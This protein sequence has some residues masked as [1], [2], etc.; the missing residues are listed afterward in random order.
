MVLDEIYSILFPK[1]IFI[2]FGMFKGHMSHIDV[3]KRCSRKEMRALGRNNP[4]G[5]IGIFTNV[6][7]G[8]NSSDSISYNDYLFHLYGIPELNFKDSICCCSPIVPV[9][10]LLLK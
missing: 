1:P 6:P 7:G 9:N 2:G 4:N 5:S 3:H 8:C 10:I